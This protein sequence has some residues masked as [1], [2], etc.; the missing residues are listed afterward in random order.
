MKMPTVSILQVLLPAP[1]YLATVVL[2]P[3]ELAQTSMNAVAASVV[4]VRIVSVWTQKAPIPVSATRALFSLRMDEH[5]VTLMSAIKGLIIVMLVS[6]L[7]LQGLSSAGRMLMSVPPIM[8]AAL[9]C[10]PTH[11]L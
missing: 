9:K 1:V 2:A 8:V 11:L 7:T 5:V 3:L 6:V 10:V 4:A